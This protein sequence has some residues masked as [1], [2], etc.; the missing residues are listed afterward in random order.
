MF[1]SGQ[2]FEP[3]IFVLFMLSLINAK[4]S[5]AKLHDGVGILLGRAVI[6]ES[7]MLLGCSC[8]CTAAAATAA[9]ACTCLFM[10]GTCIPLNNPCNIGFGVNL[11]KQ[12]ETGRGIPG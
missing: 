12:L 7:A 2:D 5:A 1:I 11:L 4:Y 6:D 9:A 3:W 8:M 10:A